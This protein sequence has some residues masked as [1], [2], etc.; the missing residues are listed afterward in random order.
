MPDT[1]QTNA[2]IR[3]WY[4]EQISQIPVSDREWKAQGLSPAERAENAWRI[5]HNARLKA[6]E[7]MSDKS[8]VE[9]LRMRNIQKYDN[10][11]GPTFEYLV[12]RLMQTELTGNDIYEE[13]IL[14]SCQTD[15]G[16]NKLL[17]L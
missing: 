5:R 15:P 7:M 8:E 6:R 9:N 3:Q 13:I 4:Q 17:G 1:P 10:P 11:D 12:E 14:L 2:E 16:I